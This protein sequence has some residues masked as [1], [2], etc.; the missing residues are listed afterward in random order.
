MTPTLRAGVA[1][2]IITPPLGIAHAGWGAQTHTRAAG[3]DMDLLATVLVLAEGDTRAA[4]VDV[5]LC[6]VSADLARPIRRAVEEL[7]G[8]PERHVRLSY[9]H[10]HSGPMLAPSWLH[11]GDEMIPAYV[12]SLP[13]RIAGAA[14]QAQSR[15]RPARVSA[16]TGSSQ[17]GV[18]RRLKLEDGRVVCGRNWTGVVDRDVVVV[19]IDDEGQRP[20]AILVHHGAHPTIMGPPNQLLTPDYPGMTRQVVEAATG[21]PCLF[22]QGAAGNVHAVVDY[23]GDPAVYRRLGAILGH[24]AA[25]LALSVKTVPTRER[26]VTVI[27]SGAPLGIY[28]DEPIGEPDGTLR[29]VA[30]SVALPLKPFA[31]EGVLAA[32]VERTDAELASARSHGDAEELVRA[33]G[34]TRRAH[35]RLDQARHF[36][37][38][39]TVAA[40]LHGLRLGGIGLCAFPGEPFAEVGLEIKRRS[41]FAHTLFSG[42]TND[43]LGYLPTDE[44]RADGGYEIDVSPF[45]PGADRAVIEESLRLLDELRAPAGTGV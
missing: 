29:V 32:E 37:G 13:Q 35:M 11:E 8:I 33:V 38:R 24:E 7:A 21:A 34:R 44:A 45:A 17:I 31:P 19:R 27:E 15:L 30:R 2:A 18:N 14:W 3:V 25:K 42:Y 41:P 39:T 5:D 10:T 43:Y 28:A 40:E 9:T 16:L 23:V 20:I 1:R 36:A 12:A 26:L 4:V 6:V 22:L